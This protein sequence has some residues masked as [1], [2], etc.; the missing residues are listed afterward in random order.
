M[1]VGNSHELFLII[2]SFQMDLTTWGAYR[3]WYAGIVRQT[4]YQTRGRYRDIVVDYEAGGKGSRWAVF[5][6]LD[7][8]EP[9]PFVVVLPCVPL[10]FGGV[11][12]FQLPYST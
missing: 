3:V 1:F 5:K 6:E 7:K 4:R 10:P 8:N 2:R 9:F 11:N 12:K